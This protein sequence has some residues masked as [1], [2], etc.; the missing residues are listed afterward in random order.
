MLETDAEAWDP[1]IQRRVQNLHTS[2]VCL[3]EDG[4]LTAR[5]TPLDKT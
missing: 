4:L 3:S 5:L 2:T 1:S